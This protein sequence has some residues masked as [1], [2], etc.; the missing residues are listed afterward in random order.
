[1]LD[2][3]FLSKSLGLLNPPAPVTILETQSLDEAISLLQTHRSGCLLVVD[4]AGKL[5]GIFTERDVVLRIINHG[6]DLKGSVVSEH[7]TKEPATAT[8][9]TTVA[10]A[11]N[12]LSHGGFRNIPIVDDEGFPV[13]LMN[14]K[15]LVDFLV[16][17]IGRIDAE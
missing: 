16:Q 8:M 1:M 9:T 5:L 2:N 6:I 11:L 4:A 13:G 12:M 7:M 14:V 10:F 15:N 3:R 17:S